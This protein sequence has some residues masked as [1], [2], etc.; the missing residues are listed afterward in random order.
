[1]TLG[2]CEDDGSSTGAVT[3]ATTPPPVLKA[4]AGIRRRVKKRGSSGS[5]A[6]GNGDGA[7]DG[8]SLHNRRNSNYDKY[9]AGRSLLMACALLLIVIGV[10]DIVI[11]IQNYFTPKNAKTKAHPRTKV[12][13]TP[14]QE[15]H[16]RHRKNKD[17]TIDAAERIPENVQDLLDELGEEE[18]AIHDDSIEE[19]NDGENGDDPLLHDAEAKDND[20]DP[21]VYAAIVEEEEEEAEKSD[22]PLVHAAEVEET[23]QREEEGH[24][25]DNDPLSLSASP[26]NTFPTLKYGTA[27]KK[28]QTAELVRKAITTGFRH[29]DTAC[30]PK[31]YN[32]KGVGEGWTTAVQELGLDRRDIWLQTKFTSLKGQDP[33]DIPYDK[34]ATLE[35]QVRQSVQQSLR[36]LQTDY[37]DSLVMHSPEK[38]WTDTFRVWSVFE[39]FVRDGTVKQIGVSNVWDYDF[40]E[41]LYTE[42]TIKPA[43]IQQ[44]FYSDTKY[45]VQIREFCLQ[46][47]IEYQAFWTLGANPHVLKN[48]PTIQELATSKGLTPETL[49]YAFCMTIGITVL[50]GATNEDHMKEDI[51]L[52]Q[53][54][55]NNGDANSKIFVNEKELTLIAN[56]LGIPDWTSPII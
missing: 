3:A 5:I 2:S 10:M 21:L 9:N 55:N 38:S 7:A 45:D 54:M 13:H 36:N 31:H 34:H 41:H 25:N 14:Q 49:L 6:S 40:V 51:V 20:D 48:N 26:L 39:E 23:T 43:V 37:L 52:L 27:W 32:E 56:A 29:I 8:V 15:E 42:S 17:I 44:R 47:R 4:G 35:D 30:Q 28:D 33:D 18:L 50:D 53:R 1:M 22:D 12:F 11:D 46:H 19:E 24:H 16:Q